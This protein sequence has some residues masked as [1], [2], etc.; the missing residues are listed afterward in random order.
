MLIDWFTVIAQAVNFLI[1]V[2]LMK[3]YLYQPILKALAEREQ[4]IAASLADAKTKM[5]EAARE[6]EEFARKNAEFDRQRA[7]LMYKVQDEAGIER[8]RLFEAA[9]KDADEFGGKL[10]GKLSGEYRSLRDSISRG[11][12]DEVFA[13]ARKTLADL[14]GATLEQRIA[15]VFMVRLQGLGSA[16]RRAWRRC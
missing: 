10:Q 6:R 4:R 11:R 7:A 5:A 9:R 8:N 14:A 2:W 16:E 15:E 1:L 3:R 12:S 13:I